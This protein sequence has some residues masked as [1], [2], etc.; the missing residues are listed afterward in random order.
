[1]EKEG[2]TNHYIWRWSKDKSTPDNWLTATPIKILGWCIGW[3]VRVVRVG[4]EHYFFTNY[5]HL[6]EE[7]EI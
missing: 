3:K 4:Y 5:P 7:Y 2:I 1:M 6:G